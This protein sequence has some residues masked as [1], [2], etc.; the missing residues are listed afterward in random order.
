MRPAGSHP[1]GKEETFVT[2]HWSQVLSAQGQ[3]PAADQALG[4]LCASYYGPVVAFLRNQGHP[5]DL[6]RELAHAFFAEVLSHR[7]SLEGADPRRGRF[8]SYL[9]GALK[10]FVANRRRYQNAQKRR[11]HVWQE[12]AACSE[13]PPALNEVPDPRTISPETAF[14][15]E[16]A[17][18]LLAHAFSVLDGEA[19][20]N[21]RYEEYQILKPWLTIEK[22]ENQKEAA[23]KLGISEA[24]IR[25]AIH[26]LRKRFREL[27]K[28]QIAQTVTEAAEVEEEL[29]H[30]I[31]TLSQEGRQ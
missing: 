9:L 13:E 15:R 8:R 5:E 2:T 11:G 6:A 7:F 29:Q 3:S 1:N 25:V 23:R 22:P 30:L 24:A 18:T 17:L 12:G 21:G 10:H 27:V 26:R 14:D 4:E 31:R 28:T 16:W 19:K 20:E